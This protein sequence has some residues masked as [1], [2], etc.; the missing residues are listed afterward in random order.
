MTHAVTRFTESLYNTPHLIGL[1][2]FDSLMYY[3]DNRNSG[4]D[5]RSNA[6]P[7]GGV[8]HAEYDYATKV[9]TL[10]VSGALTYRSNVFTAL[11]GA[12]SYQQLQSDFDKLID[13][14]A[15]TIVLA[16][17]SGGGQ[18]Y[19]A[20]E[21]AN[22]LRKTADAKGIRLVSYCDGQMASA[23]YVLGS[24]AHEV[25]LNPESECGSIGVVVK[26]RNANEQLKKAGIEDT[27]LI[28]GANK[29]PFAN[30]GS[31]RK[32]F[33]TDIQA[34]VDSLYG[35]FTG[36]VALHRG[37]SIDQVTN[38][39]ARMFTASEAVKLGLADSTMTR[40]QFNEYVSSGI[41]MTRKHTASKAAQTDTNAHKH[42]VKTAKAA[43]ALASPRSMSDPHGRRSRIPKGF[44]ETATQ[45]ILRST[46][47]QSDEQF[48]EF[49][50]KLEREWIGGGK[51][52]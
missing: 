20:F 10:S 16:V 50:A 4:I 29:V 9:G 37:M 38:T 34:K 46:N 42:P 24:V 30:D 12:T 32:E 35:E 19:G 8:S 15:K 21:T 43:T 22:Y 3:F 13:A 18:A 49:V 17:D 51:A 2:A 52:A 27:Y 7:A 33:I 23:A 47:S 44:S 41:A 1:S 40:E 6:T 25:V 5:A 36:F 14:G 11:C 26:L 28:G 39:K 48:V 45:L 31:W